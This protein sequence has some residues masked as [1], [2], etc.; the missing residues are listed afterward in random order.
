METAR[1][2]PQ[3]T[4]LWLAAWEWFTIY[5]QLFAWIV[6]FN[7]AVAIVAATGTWSWAHTHRVQFAVANTLICVLARNEVSCPTVCNIACICR[8]Y[9]R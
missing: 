4:P 1:K 6:G 5:R 2:T 3:R 9:R 8:T 7:L